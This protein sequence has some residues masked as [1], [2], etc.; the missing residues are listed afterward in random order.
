MRGAQQSLFPNHFVLL[1]LDTPPLTPG[2]EAAV[3]ADVFKL[4]PTYDAA[5][6][7]VADAEQRN[8]LRLAV[9]GAFRSC[10]LQ[11]LCRQSDNMYGDRARRMCSG[12]SA[13]AAGVVT[14]TA[15]EVVERSRR[16]EQRMRLA[17]E[18]GVIP[19][20]AVSSS[21]A[22]AAGPSQV[23]WAVAT[24][25]LMFDEDFVRPHGAA[26]ARDMLPTDVTAA[27]D[28]ALRQCVAVL[29]GSGVTPDVKDG[30]VAG[31]QIH[32]QRAVNEAQRQETQRATRRAAAAAAA[33]LK[34]GTGDDVPVYL[35]WLEA[36][37]PR[38][39][40]FWLTSTGRWTLF[41]FLM[42]ILG[43]LKVM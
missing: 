12:L 19:R 13:T 20:D 25:R 42:L 30:F 1:L 17:A 36:R 14:A 18:A 35:A 6:A 23:A 34:A 41:V 40:R 24:A 26:S 43:T 21:A 9:T 7:F 16:L 33:A 10:T 8:E 39:H 22:T 3:L 5:G 37:I 31:T 11:T 28:V 4:E 29:D 2:E 27:F 15:D 32:R 38:Q